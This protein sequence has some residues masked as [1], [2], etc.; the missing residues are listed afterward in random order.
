MFGLTQW[1]FWYWWALAVALITLEIFSP[2]EFFI[3][4]GLAAGIM[5]LLAWQVDL[6]WQ[7]QVFLFAVISVVSLMLGRA[8]FNKNPIQTDQPNLNRR[9]QNL[10]GK[11]FEVEQ[12]IVNGAGR[13]RVGETTWKVQ[14]EDCSVGSRVRVVGINSAV[15]QV[16]LIS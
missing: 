15:L 8:W 10:I 16:D 1:V 2:A 12:A 13:V 9:G 3:W 5:G 7:W 14:G 11:T 6:N 4:L